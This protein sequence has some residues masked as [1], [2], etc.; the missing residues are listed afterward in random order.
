MVPVM[1]QPTETPRRSA[2]AAAV[3]SL[4]V[5]GFGHLYER[6]WRA[7]L[8]FLTP[9]TLLLALVGGIVA[10]DGL[11]GLVGLLITPFGLSAAGIL[12]ILLAVWRGVAAADAWRGAVRRESGLR[13]I[14]TSFAGLALSLVAALSFI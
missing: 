14:G 7:A 5:P 4:L 1:S 2:F 3:F 10:A 12:N 13:A 9:P 6:R 8:L 11:P